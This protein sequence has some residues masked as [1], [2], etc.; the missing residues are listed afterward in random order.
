L[1][2]LNTNLETLRRLL[3]APPSAGATPPDG[4]PSERR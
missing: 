3:D 4:A 2:R 1:E